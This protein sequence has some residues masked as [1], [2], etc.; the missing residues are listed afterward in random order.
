M[1]ILDLS[2]SWQMRKDGET[3]WVDA[4]VPGCVHTDLLA[5]GKI[6]DPYYRDN[7]Q[8]LFWIGRSDWIYRRAFQVEAELLASERVMLECDGLDTFAT[9]LVNDTQV[10]SADNQFRRWEFDVKPALREGENTI[11]VLLHS[12]YPYMEE[13]QG[14][15]Y[16]NLTGVGQHRIDGSNRVR[17]SQCNFGWDWGPMCVTYGIWRDIRIVGR[18]TACLR[19]VHITQDHGTEGRVTLGVHADVEPFSE[20]A[21]SLRVTVAQDGKVVA[22][23]TESV[24]A[25]AADVQLEIVEPELWWPNG[26]GEQPLY[27]VSAELRD[28]NGVLDTATKTVGLRTLRL[29]RRKEAAG[30]SFE[31]VVN[32]VPFFAKGANWIPADTFVTRISSAQY[33][34]L[35]RSAADANMNMLR[36]WGGGIY[37]P[38]AFYDLCDRYGI[39]VW[40]D[41]M[42][43]CSAYAAFDDAFMRSVEAEAR[44][45]VARL[46]HHPSIAL[47]C[48]NN[49]IEQIHAA[50]VGDEPGKMTWQEYQS[51]F[52][53]LLP[54]VVTALDPERDYWPSSPHSPYGA[55]TDANNPDWGDAHL[56]DVWHGRKPFEWYRSCRHR[57]NSE[58]GFQSFPEPRIVES[59]T[60]PEDR[61]ITSYIMELH[62]R[63]G[64]GNDAIIQYMLSWFRL[65]SSHE[66]TLWVSQILQGMAIKYAV[67]HWRRQMPR[68]MGTLYWQLNDCWPVASWSSIDYYHNWKALHYMARR[69][70]APL[71]VSAVEDEQS[72]T[73]EVHVTS[74]L[75]VE[76]ECTVSWE[77][78]DVDGGML[79]SGDLPAVVGPG[80]SQVVGSIHCT[81]VRRT[82]GER[83]LIVWMDLVSDGQVV[84]T[85][86]ATFARP[87]HLAL[88]RRR[89]DVSVQALSSGGF[90]ISL[91]TAAP[92][93]WVWLEVDG[94]ASRCSDSFFHLRPG[95]PV[96]VEVYPSQ[97]LTLGAFKEKL[98]VR[99]LVETY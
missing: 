8:Q 74:D 1:K 19:D 82:V 99:S 53:E 54:Q 57:F 79:G 69:F 13:Q 61:N 85:N 23:A 98:R 81:D 51:L 77:L 7:E 78:S 37:E 76:R 96:T 40:Q 16:L 34:D 11:Q 52:D 50:F 49:E 3:E 20:A 12:V 58:F 70:F 71:L 24:A 4:V 38:A 97:E 65:P 55:R 89:P 80:Q 35:V 90:Q 41:F 42:F 2:G 62:Q 94:T 47:W 30:E 92:L 33:E 29:R 48:G 43:A 36:V 73:V 56:W 15:R 75:R 86:M 46:R 64:I 44:D 22:E 5:A 9:V 10:G 27:T 26:L 88:R 32:G 45:T 91:T 84:S 39:C 25:S 59:Y 18:D 66:M 72:G 68:G 93:L 31:F 95:H 28:R 21:T 6:D 83:G 87:K 14:V 63:S 17:K 67:E 60:A